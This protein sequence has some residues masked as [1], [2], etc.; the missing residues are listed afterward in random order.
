M[1]IQGPLPEVKVH[2]TKRN[3]TIDTIKKTTVINTHKTTVH[4]ANVITNM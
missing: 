1:Q 4:Q 2:N 3:D